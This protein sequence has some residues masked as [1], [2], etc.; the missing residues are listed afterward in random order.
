MNMLGP[1]K[2]KR[3]IDV[4]SLTVCVSVTVVAWC[5]W[6]GCALAESSGNADGGGG[7]ELGSQIV[8][9][10]NQHCVRCHGEQGE[11]QGEIHL[12]QLTATSLGDDLELLDDLVRVIDLREMPPE[13]EAP[14]LSGERD[15]LL[16]DLQ[17]LLRQR[18]ESRDDPSGQT[19]SS[20]SR[21]LVRRMNRFQ[22]NNAVIDLLDLKCIVFTLPERML[23][24]HRDYFRPE[25]G[26]MADVVHVGSRPLGKSQMIEPRLAGVAAFPQDLRA[27]HGF[28]NRADH[29]TMSP[30][31]M[32][33]FLQ[34]GQSIVNSPDFHDKN[35]GCWDAVFADPIADRA[36][37]KKIREKR[38]RSAKEETSK[39]DR[40]AE[41]IVNEQLKTRIARLLFRAFRGDPGEQAVMRYV[42]YA[43]QCINRGDSFTHAMK[44]T[45]AAVLASPRF[46]Y[47][48]DACD[49]AVTGEPFPG[50]L[51]LANRMSFFLWGSIPDAELLGL[52][53]SGELSD[54]EVLDHQ[55]DRML[56]DRK[57][58]RFCESFPSQWLQLERIIS[59]I[60]NRDK[61]PTF[62]FAKYR[63]SMHMMAEPLL[64]FEAVLIENQPITQL[65]DADFTYR[66]S[67]LESA[68]GS[69]QTD[70]S[71]QRKSQQQVQV[72]A[73]HR[74][75]IT[76]RRSGGV[77]TNAAVMTMTSGPLESKPIT[78][79]AWVASVIFNN[80]PS[81]P[82]ADVPPLA[83]KPPE[84]QEHLS[85]RERL[86]LH[87]TAKSC[88]QCHA[89]LDPLGFA[90][91][92]Y[93]PIG[94]WR[95]QYEN[96]AAVDPS[97]VLFRTHSFADVVEFKDALLL[98]KDRFTK[99]LAGH[100]LSFALARQLTPQDKAQLEPVAKATAADEYRMQTL[101]KQIVFS[102]P[103]SGQG[104]PAERT[105][106]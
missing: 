72:L 14:L 49:P 92:N 100:L 46:L 10:L 73:F 67:H 48:V 90:L 98:E 94:R 45:V 103:F 95:T 1:D 74:V 102:R 68:Y 77:I 75:P 33:S 71:K 69:L 106:R 91:E 34:L 50:D 93:D 18:L 52:A 62:Y 55:V 32:E 36:S 59:S 80:P 3:S 6:A 81:P 31:L 86:T 21:T 39:A 58:R 17:T 99:A 76:D 57:I 12:A 4:V 82:P 78:R 79:G 96:G 40:S 27:E 16:A 20:Q 15:A 87:R 37:N 19:P 30:L 61:F 9:R 7:G 47:L 56:R 104:D 26:K 65:I 42:D 70:G 41:Q 83:D 60:P 88:R 53:R 101:I 35:V 25:T 22:Y 44:A 85:L 2:T 97:G 84:G 11:I 23:R 105:V 29:L 8:A 51:I 43:Q 38:S 89:K 13:D 63:N 66:S 5:V 24:V 64:L 54:P 28:D